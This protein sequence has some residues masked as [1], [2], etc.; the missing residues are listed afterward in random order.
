MK[1]PTPPQ[2]STNKP[3]GVYIHTYG[4]QMN[5][6]DSEQMLAQ[7][8]QQGYRQMDRPEDADLVLVNTCAIREH[9]EH[10]L[11]SLLGRLRALKRERPQLRIGVG[12]CVAQLRGEGIFQRAP[13][14]DLVF[15]TD[16]LFELPAM[17][18]AVERGERV[19]RTEWRRGKKGPQAFIP[20]EETFSD[21]TLGKRTPRV[22]AQ[23][24][25]MKGCNNRCTFCVVPQTRG[26]ES[27][28]PVEDILAEA[29]ALIA[30]GV[31]E[32][33]LLGQNVNSY[34]ANGVR[35]AELL[36]RLNDL[37]GRFRIRYTT[38]HPKDL[39][40]TLADAHATLPKL[41]E[42]VHLPL[43]SGSDAVLRA[44]RRNHSVQDYLDKI[45]LLRERVPQIAISTDIIVGFPG[46]TEADFQDTLAIVRAVSFEHIYAFKYSKRPG[47]PASSMSNQVVE[48]EKTD[49][50]SRLL[51]LQT[52]QQREYTRT[53]IATRQEVLV[54]GPHPNGDTVM[55]RTRS[56]R[57]V[58]L[59]G[60]SYQAGAFVDV[61]IVAVRNFRLVGKELPQ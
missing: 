55:G 9:A 32:I 52:K 15:G 40:E 39:R 59:Q 58:L 56:N 54:E 46:E 14:T 50:L 17:L 11:Y 61:E 43:Q 33:S 35:F 23:I 44:M 8:Q 57:P 25:I 45:A 21:G 29:Q 6:Y 47:V 24:A 5:A 26:W 51:T 48:A 16:T 30:S 19:L 7:L 3:R 2:F 37:I 4:C 18:E 12:G 31:R 22:K 34:R 10:K 41:C 53:L 20:R 38:S 27:S 42:Q 36:Q 60:G 28:R 13:Q 1:Q 49:R